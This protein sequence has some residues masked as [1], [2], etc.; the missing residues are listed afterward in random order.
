MQEEL[1][2]R[3]NKSMDKKQ[4]EIILR[5][6]LQAITD[7]LNEMDEEGERLATMSAYR[8]LRRQRRKT[9][10]SKKRVA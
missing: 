8:T 6:Q 5:E 7:E 1:S 3:L 4:K 2:K 10:A 9:E